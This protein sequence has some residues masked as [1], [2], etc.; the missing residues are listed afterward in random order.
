MNC[1]GHAGQASDRQ[2][3][4]VGL[5]HTSNASDTRVPRP[6]R[7]CDMTNTEGRKTFAVSRPR[8]LYNCD[9]MSGSVAAA[10][11]DRPNCKQASG[12]QRV[13]GRLW[14]H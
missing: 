2:I 9:E 14:N 7:K 10:A 6:F 4:R 11:S 13:G 1:C 5:E 3:I 8:A 12:H